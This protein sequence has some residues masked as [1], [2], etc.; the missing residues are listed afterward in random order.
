MRLDYKREIKGK[1]QMFCI[2][3]LEEEIEKTD[4]TFQDMSV[5]TR[6]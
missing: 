5:E 3:V 2:Q 6:G 1:G 4:I